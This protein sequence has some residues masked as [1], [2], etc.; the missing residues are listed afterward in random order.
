MGVA[1]DDGLPDAQSLLMM[2]SA[3]RRIADLVAASEQ[4]LR[5]E[6]IRHVLRVS[7]ETMTEALEE[8]V[9]AGLVRRAAQDPLLYLPRD[10]ALRA[11]LRDH[12]GEERLARLQRQIAGASERVF[13]D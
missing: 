12:L 3:A 11:E 4:P 7:E 6:V 2:S 1:V 13:G 10:E 9:N 5:Y 8:I